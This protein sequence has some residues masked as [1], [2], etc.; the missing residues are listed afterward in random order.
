MARSPK[1]VM[2]TLR[3]PTTLRAA[4]RSAARDDHRSVNGLV[5]ALLW[6]T[7]QENTP[8]MR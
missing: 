5:V 4:L 7:F 3:I 2:L 1:T 6:E 8:K